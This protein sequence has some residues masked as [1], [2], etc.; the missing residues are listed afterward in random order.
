MTE[1]HTTMER[2]ISPRAESLQAFI[3]QAIEQLQRSGARGDAA[4]D[5]LLFFGSWNDSIPRLLIRDPILKPIEAR[6][7]SVM[8]TLVEPAGPATM[9][10]YDTLAVYCNVGSRSTVSH[11]LLILRITR[12]I[13]LCARVRDDGGRYA[14]NVYALHDEPT[15]LGDAMHLDASYVAFLRE[16]TGHR[17]ARV[18][19]LAQSV[20]DTIE[21]AIEEG[22]DVTRDTG[23]HVRVY[24]RVSFFGSISDPAGDSVDAPLAV[25]GSRRVA[26]N[27]R[28]QKVDLDRVQK[29]DS[30]NQVQKV[31]SGNENEEKQSLNN[32]VQKVYSVSCSSSNN[33]KTTT[34]KDVSPTLI[35][36][37]RLSSG[38]QALVSG[39]FTGLDSALAQDVLDELQGRLQDGSANPVR[40]PVAWLIASSKRAAAGEFRL[41]S[42]GLGVR[43]A[44]ARQAALDADE[45]ARASPPPV[46]PDSAAVV[47]NALTQRVE[48]L[49]IRRRNRS[50]GASE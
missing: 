36:P 4:P 34:T 45:K 7:W 50:A 18:R 24:Q 13:S 44:R 10:D 16:M 39:Y 20:L 5:G 14:G 37:K 35:W 47:H 28:V 22:Q 8:R 31:Y 17:N 27:H 25:S 11:A 12:W 29:T 43:R 23:L 26:L 3:Q 40:N 9:P 48:A 42:L 19:H 33:K 1:A 38:E 32:Q 2:E 30:V 41:T 6:L 15:T 46:T 21:E 49:R